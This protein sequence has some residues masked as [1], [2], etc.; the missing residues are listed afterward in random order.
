MQAVILAGGKGTRLAERLNGKPKPLVDVDG[1][2]LLERQILS[3]Q[4]HG[5]TEVLV[6][7]NHAADQIEQFFAE[8]DFTCAV[9]LIDDGAPRGTAGA[10]LACFDRLAPR[11]LVVYGD[12]LFDIDVPHLLQG[13]ERAGGE[14]TLLLHPNDHPADSDLV[15]VDE[16]GWITSF[17]SY[18]HPPGAE[19]RNLVNA[20]FYVIERR[21]LENWA[22]ADWKGDFAKDL[23]PALLTEGVKLHGYLSYEYIK[24]LGTP[25]RLDKVE[26]H[27][28]SGLVAR[29]SRRTQ[30]AAVFVDRDGT[31]NA[32]RDYVRTAADLIVL[33]GAA[34]AIQHFNAAEFRVVLVTN[35]PVL[36]R[37]E[38]DWAEMGR[39]Q[40]RLETALGA[41]GGYLD[42]TYICPHHP[43]S[44]FPGEVAALKIACDC[45]KPGTLNFEAAIEALNID[46]HRSWMIGDS[47]ADMLAAN[48]A[49]LRSVLVLTGEAG[50]DGKWPGMPDFTVADIAEAADLITIDYPR[51]LSLLATTIEAIEPGEIV[52]ISGASPDEMARV[53]IALRLEL[54][55][56][57]FVV[58]ETS[59]ISDDAIVIVQSDAAPVEPL[60]AG[61]RRH[62]IDV[63]F[64]ERMA[65]LTP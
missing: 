15:E 35:Q 12:T 62:Q 49:G 57:G 8:R 4:A 52:Q 22:G 13:H 37:G 29:A 19:L 20:A 27:L 14:A 46:R 65:S 58:G 43:D 44:G 25:K 18:P 60:L 53:A 11:F 5:V 59:P 42:A 9:H 21:A 47:T 45:R 40:A 55:R 1:V 24:D 7:V 32:L 38:C 23:F 41:A 10:V 28:R 56:A 50:R 6:L 39:I 17:H 26:A 33:P 36:A 51:Y 63:D 2:P 54:E 31:L 61:R 30:Q 64:S 34:A 3:L 48:R 16:A